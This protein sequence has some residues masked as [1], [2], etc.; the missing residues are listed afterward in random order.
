MNEGYFYIQRFSKKAL[1]VLSEVCRGKAHSVKFKQIYKKNSINPNIF[2]LF[3]IPVQNNFLADKKE[4]LPES[5]IVGANHKK[6]I[7]CVVIVG[8]VNL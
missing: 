8:S 7:P 2:T 4:R 6:M 5:G 1:Y 3:F